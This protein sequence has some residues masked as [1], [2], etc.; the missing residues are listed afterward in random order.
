MNPG[1]SK[2]LIAASSRP[3]VLSILA[4]ADNYG[5]AIIREVKRLSGGHLD[6]KEG[7]LYPVLHRLEAEKL[8]EASWRQVDGRRRKYYRLT[9]AGNR[10]LARERQEWETMNAT[11]GR[12]WASV[13]T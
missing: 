10:A 9:E 12:A 3:L 8:I 2:D 11:L 1:P 6:W 7:M 5:Y 13:L 4:R